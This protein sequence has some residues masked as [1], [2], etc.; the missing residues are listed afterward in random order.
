MSKPTST[1]V[2]AHSSCSG[3]SPTA[4]STCWL[5]QDGLA[6][7]EAESRAVRESLEDTRKRYEV[8]L[9]PGTDLKEAQARDDLAQARLLS[10]RRSLESAR[11]ALDEITGTGRS[12]AAATAGAVSRFPPL[13]P[14]SARNLGCAAREQ[15]PRIALVPNRRSSLPRPTTRAAARNCCPRCDLV[16]RVGHDDSTDYSLGQKRDD[17]RVGVE[18]N[19]PIYTGGINSSRVRQADADLRVAEADLQARDARNRTRNPP[20]LSPGTNRLR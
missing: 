8:E 4:I 10:A 7:A 14:A 12:A 18:L 9:V 20:A 3:A 13:T 17:A 6:L 15:S 16:A 11:D 5:A 1:C 19:V 2:T